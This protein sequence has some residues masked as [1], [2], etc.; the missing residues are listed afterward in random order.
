[1]IDMKI[2]MQWRCLLYI[3]IENNSSILLY[4][5]RYVTSIELSSDAIK[6]NEL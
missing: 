3:S 6:I 4:L 5:T 1:M 2:H